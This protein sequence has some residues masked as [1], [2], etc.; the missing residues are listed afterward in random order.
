MTLK[1]P[2]VSQPKTATGGQTEKNE[3]KK[4]TAWTTTTSNASHII[5]SFKSLPVTSSCCCY[6]RLSMCVRGESTA[7]TGEM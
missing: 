3:L 7:G 4:K 1:M 6:F 2:A 5:H